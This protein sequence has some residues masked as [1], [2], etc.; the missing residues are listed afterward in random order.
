MS[1]QQITT[2]SQHKWLAKLL[3]YDYKIEY[4]L[5]SLNLVPDAVSLRHEV[6]AIQTISA[7]IFDCVHHID[8]ACNRDPEAQLIISSIQQG[9]PT[10]KGFTFINNRLYYKDKIFVPQSSEWR[11]KLLFEFHS[12]LQAGHSGYLRTFMRLSRNFTWP[13]M[14]KD[15]KTFIAACDQCQRQSYET[16]R[17]PGLLQPLPIPEEAWVDVSMEFIDGLPNSQGKNAILVVIDRLAKYAHF[18]DVTHPYIA[19]IIV[20]TY[21]KEVFRLHGMPRSKMMQLGNQPTLLST[22]SLPSDPTVRPQLKGEGLVRIILTQHHIS[23]TKSP[24]SRSSS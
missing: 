1:D 23:N 20:D 22:V 11:S 18:I 2:P 8:Q 16:I 19:S 15:T 6:C 14:R 17:P 21:M 7:P 24:V 9:T 4:R 12:S 13:K 5:G 10:K 3:G